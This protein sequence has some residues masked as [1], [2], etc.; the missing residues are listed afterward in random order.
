M[1]C[2]DA[3]INY[4][5]RLQFRKK[6]YR[7]RPDFKKKSTT[8]REP[9]LNKSGIT[10]QKTKKNYLVE[11]GAATCSTLDLMISTRRVG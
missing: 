3:R 4:V 5:S 10:S 6:A 9:E 1:D 8:G 2:L 7:S 11:T